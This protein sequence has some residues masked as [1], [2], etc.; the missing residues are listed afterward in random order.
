MHYF[1]HFKQLWKYVNTYLIDHEHGDW[2]EGGLDKQ[3]ALKKSQKGHI[4][5]ATY[6]TY[7]TLSNCIDELKKN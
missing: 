1:D 5:K 4:W 6:H 3:P 7:R 2:Y